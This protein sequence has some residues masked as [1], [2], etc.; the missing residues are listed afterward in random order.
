MCPYRQAEVIVGEQSDETNISPS[1]KQ[2]VST[3]CPLADWN[4]ANKTKSSK[5]HPKLLQPLIIP[6]ST[7][8]NPPRSRAASKLNSHRG[9]LLGTDCAL[10]R[11][12]IEFLNIL[13]S[14]DQI[15]PV[16][17]FPKRLPTT[18]W[19]GQIVVLKA[20]TKGSLFGTILPKTW[21]CVLDTSQ[22]YKILEN[23]YAANGCFFK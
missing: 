23:I 10:T 15:W 6:S 11:S 21:R 4:F 7:S 3:Q 13:Q 22:S 20:D 5:G 16:W 17:Y 2:E 12:I 14:R 18:Q 1:R 9:N 19:G 8:S